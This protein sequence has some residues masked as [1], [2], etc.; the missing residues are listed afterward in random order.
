M[1][2]DY[3]NY[4]RRKLSFI[5]FIVKLVLKRVWN[6]M[7]SILQMLHRWHLCLSQLLG[8]H[9]FVNL[10]QVSRLHTIQRLMLSKGAK[11]TKIDHIT[12][13]MQYVWDKTIARSGDMYKDDSGISSLVIKC[14]GISNTSG[15]KFRYLNF[16]CQNCTEVFAETK[17]FFLKI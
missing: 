5:T 7:I 13:I 1:N 8:A 9:G 10:N 14:F 11:R 3:Q 15:T 6:S 4:N 12:V 16:L 17:S 2:Q